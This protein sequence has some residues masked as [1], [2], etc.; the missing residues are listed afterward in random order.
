MEK[1]KFHL[2]APQESGSNAVPAKFDECMH[3][4]GVGNN[5]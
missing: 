5:F 2:C 4:S 1:A 3:I